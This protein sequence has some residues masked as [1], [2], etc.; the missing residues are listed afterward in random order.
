MKPP[1]PEV[2]RKG[3]V[4]RVAG[5]PDEGGAELIALAFLDLRFADGHLERWLGPGSVGE[6]PQGHGAV[7][8][9]QE[10]VRASVGDFAADIMAD[11]ARTY[12][13]ENAAIVD[14]LPFDDVFIE[15]N[16]SLARGNGPPF[17]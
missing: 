4:V 11:V 17:R 10:W 13:V 1:A 2:V 15:W 9:L 5:G 16:S 7:V 12:A 6:L 14:D 3:A 8:A